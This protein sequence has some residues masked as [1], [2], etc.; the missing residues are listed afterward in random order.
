MSEE[1]PENSAPD[2]TPV[3]TPAEEE[4]AAG[5]VVEEEPKSRVGLGF[6]SFLLLLVAIGL[7]VTPFVWGMTQGFVPD[8]EVKSDWVTWLG[9]FAPYVQGFPFG[10]FLYVFLLEVVG[11]LSLRKFRPNL[12]GALFV[13]V[14]FAVLAAVT[15][16]CVFLGGEHG[17]APLAMG[18]LM[19]VHLW[20]SLFFAVV[21]IFAFLAKAWARLSGRGN[22][23]YPIVMI[24]GLALGGVALHHGQLLTNG[25]DVLSDFERLAGV[26]LTP[27]TKEQAEE[28]LLEMEGEVEEKEE[29]SEAE[30]VGEVVGEELPAEEEEASEVGGTGEEAPVDVDEKIE[31]VED[32]EP[33]EEPAGGGESDGSEEATPGVAGEKAEPEAEV[34]VVEE[35]PVVEE[36]EEVV[37]EVPV[38]EEA[39]EVVEEEAQ[40]IEEVIENE[41][42]VSEGEK[43]EEAEVNLE[44]LPEPEPVV[45]EAVSEVQ[46]VESA[47]EEVVEDAKD[48]GEEI[49]K[50]E[51]GEAVE[52]VLEEVEQSAQDAALELEKQVEEVLEKVQQ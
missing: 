21:V 44:K 14:L 29:L 52:E 34:K 32:A 35:V 22:V 46:E 10:V 43:V 49:L 38:V 15:T 30:T 41:V 2:L 17:A 39:A 45:E 8:A 3:K 19:G 37:E 16:Y 12:S 20:G 9:D 33:V 11:V 24:L 28:E 1:N 23:F 18:S 31:V 26:E 13:C 5:K 48:E 36:A 50:G 51:G 4:S 40:V 27:W 47:V 42:E 25:K 6:L 7:V